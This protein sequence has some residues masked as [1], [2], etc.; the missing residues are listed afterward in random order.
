LR[1]SRHY[2]RAPLRAPGGRASW[3]ENDSTRVLR[4][5]GGRLLQSTSIAPDYR[6]YALAGCAPP[7]P[8]L[9]RVGL[10]SWLSPGN[11]AE[12]LKYKNTTSRYL[13]TDTRYQNTT[14][15]CAD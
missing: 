14:W 11:I 13:D 15:R 8:G 10:C 7:K 1:F 2:R 9:L 5:S 6:L 12:C 3:N 4:A